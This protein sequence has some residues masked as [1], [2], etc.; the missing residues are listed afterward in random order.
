MKRS[1]LRFGL[2]LP[3]LFAHCWQFGPDSFPSFHAGWNGRFQLRPNC[4]RSFLDRVCRLSFSIRSSGTGRIVQGTF[5]FL[6]ILFSESCNKILRLTSSWFAE[7]NV[8][9]RHYTGSDFVHNP[10]KNVLPTFDNPRKGQPRRRE[11]RQ[12]CLKLVGMRRLAQ[13][14][15]PRRRKWNLCL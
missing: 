2:H 7:H 9:S 11:T 10:R 3:A 6:C 14:M 13:T 8:F 15:R 5:A 1:C 4:R 12:R